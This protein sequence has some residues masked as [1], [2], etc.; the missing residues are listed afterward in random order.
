MCFRLN[1]QTTLIADL[2][3]MIIAKATLLMLE[4]LLCRIVHLARDFGSFPG[5]WFRQIGYVSASGDTTIVK[6]GIATKTTE[7]LANGSTSP[8]A[9]PLAK[10]AV[11][12]Y[13]RCLTMVILIGKPTQ[14]KRASLFYFCS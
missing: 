9:M 10:K 1:L 13:H 6:K 7:P 2:K 11:K 8:G 14:S 4:A 3:R 5:S 12:P